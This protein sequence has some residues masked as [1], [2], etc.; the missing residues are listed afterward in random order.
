MMESELFGYIARSCEDPPKF[1]VQTINSV[2]CVY[3]RF[4]DGWSVGDAVYEEDIVS[5]YG[6]KCPECDNE[7]FFNQELGEMYCPLNHV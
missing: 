4:K 5:Q 1:F 2:I 7:M 3:L 6:R